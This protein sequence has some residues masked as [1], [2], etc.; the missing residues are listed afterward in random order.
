[1]PNHEPKT[2]HIPTG[3]KETHAEREARG[4]EYM[5]EEITQKQKALDAKPKTLQAMQDA[6]TRYHTR[7]K[8]TS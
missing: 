8:P 5:R 3:S 7:F 4:N 1:M 6:S 2:E